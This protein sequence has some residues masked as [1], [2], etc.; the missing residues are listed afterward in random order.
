MRAMLLLIAVATSAASAQQVR[1]RNGFWVGAGLGFGSLQLSC[2]GCTNGPRSNA[3]SGFVKLGGTINGHLLLGGETD[4]WVRSSTTTKVAGNTSAT[5]YYYPAPASGLFLRAGLG[6]A[7]Y[8]E[9]SAT[10]AA[11]GVGF[12]VGAGYDFAVGPHT[13]LTSVANFNWGAPG[14]VQ[15]GLL[16]L[17]SVKQNLL[18]LGLGITWH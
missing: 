17:P 8:Q 11:I 12:V 16:T 10:N 7:Y 4:L 6:I 3:L 5:A 1:T 15:R 14:D 18:Q 13:S 2:S 9:K